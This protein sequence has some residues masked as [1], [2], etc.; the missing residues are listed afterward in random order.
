M[1]TRNKKD[2]MKGKQ[3]TECKELKEFRG[4]SQ[5]NKSKDKQ[6]MLIMKVLDNDKILCLFSNNVYNI[7]K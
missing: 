5:K 2:F 1:N 6:F 3:V 7:Y 4:L